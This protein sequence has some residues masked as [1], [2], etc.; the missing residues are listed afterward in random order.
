MPTVVMTSA[1]S[2]TPKMASVGMAAESMTLIAVL[3]VRNVIPQAAVVRISTVVWTQIVLIIATATLEAV[4]VFVRWD[5][6]AMRAVKR[7]NAVRIMPVFKSVTQ[8]TQRVAL[9]VNIAMNSIDV[10]TFV[11]PMQ[12]VVKDNSATLSQ[13]NA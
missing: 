6:V 1:V 3:K 4:K 5:A 9:K 13:T 10:Q 8:M 12:I 11:L 2:V 7:T